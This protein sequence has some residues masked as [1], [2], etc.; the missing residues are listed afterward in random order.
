M[1][2]AAETPGR[3]AARPRPRPARQR[4]AGGAAPRRPWRTR[5][6]RRTIPA[7]PPCPSPPVRRHAGRAAIPRGCRCHAA[8]VNAG[9]VRP[10]RRRSGSRGCPRPRPVP[11]A[12]QAPS[13]RRSRSPRPITV[14]RPRRWPCGPSPGA[15]R[16]PPTGRRPARQRA[17]PG[18]RKARSRIGL[19][20][21]AQRYAEHRRRPA[22]A[23]RPSGA[24]GQQAAE[25]HRGQAGIDQRLAHRVRRRVR[26]VRAPPARSADGSAVP[27]PAAH[28]E[29]VHVV[30]NP[31]PPG[32]AANGPRRASRRHPRRAPAGPPSKSATKRLPC[33]RSARTPT[34]GQVEHAGAEAQLAAGGDRRHHGQ[35]LADFPRQPVDPGQPA[36]QRHRAHVLGQGQHRR[37]CSLLALQQRRQA[38]NDDA[39]GAWATIR[40]GAIQFAQGVAEVSV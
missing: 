36:E 25:R 12:P 8:P 21:E 2:R 29:G 35:H 40:L 7:P 28:A 31:L 14:S 9:R 23:D 13:T 39:G 10:C 6:G 1:A 24:V 17:R 32:R 27:R 19:R 20:Q 15:R 5:R 4:H 33:S 22:G 16:P 3:S 18:A 11:A 30:A 37:L 34:G 38:A 26:Q